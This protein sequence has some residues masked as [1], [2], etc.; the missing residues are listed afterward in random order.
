MR[1]AS[2]GANKHIVTQF[3]VVM[4]KVTRGCPSVK[5]VPALIW[6]DIDI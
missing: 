6:Q 3:E 1:F 5:H 4:M 2:L